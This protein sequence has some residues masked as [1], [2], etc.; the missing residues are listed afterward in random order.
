LNSPISIPD[1]PDP[2]STKPGTKPGTNGPA[3][4]DRRSATAK[5]TVSGAYLVLQSSGRW[6]DVFRLSSPAEAIIGRASSNQIVI[7]SDQASRRHARIAFAAG[8][9]TVEDMG[10]RNGTFVNGQKIAGKQDLCDRDVIA[11]AGYAIT[12]S[13]R[14]DGGAGEPVR[15]AES[16]QATDD[17][18][19]MEIDPESITDRRRHSAHLHTAGET[20]SATETSRRL[21]HL[22]F[23]VAQADQA[24]QAVEK[25]L[26]WI[27]DQIQF[28]TVGVYV[29]ES[30]Q[31]NASIADIPLVA[32]RQTGARS[33]RRPPIELMKSV[34]GPAGQSILARN[35]MGDGELA[36]ENSRGEMDVESVIMAAVRDHDERLLGLVHVTTTDDNPPLDSADLELIVAAG[37]ILAQSLAHLLDRQRLSRSLSKSRKQVRRLQEQIGDKVRIVGR[38]ESIGNVIQQIGLVAPTNSTVLIAGESGVGKELVASA[39][40]HTS[41]RKDG[42]FVCLNC[43]ALSPT[44]L[45]SELFGHEQGAF[46]GA[47]DRKLGKFEL[48]DGGTLML[49]EIGEM[50]A[51]VQAKFLRVLEGH[52]FERVG[53]Q[54]AIRADVRV[55]AATN[56]DLRSMVA[57]GEFRQDLYYRLHVVEIVVPPLRNRG[58]DCLQLADFF[59]QRFNA[60]MGRKIEGFTDAAKKRLVGYSW[61]GNIRELKNVIERAVVLNT[62]TQVDASDLTL[63]P[64][65]AGGTPPTDTSM[66]QIPLSELERTH[67]E[68]VLRHTEGNKSRAASILGIERSTLDRKLKKYGA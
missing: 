52:P 30:P 41:A 28:D 62:K 54:D 45:E 23:A 36:T 19:T 25:V 63:S 56:R 33:Y 9:W 13:R 67:I 43:A 55:V 59:L 17:Q 20:K 58:K 18:I 31:Q 10:S 22:A 47:T 34:G 32:T 2:T 42:P 53:G 57:S 64:A 11:V 15:S 3:G 4:P 50:S 35:V 5:G 49:D 12:F 48:A 68:Q 39:I 24:I 6:S 46:T 1:S 44:L 21:L 60:E 14:I 26:D 16:S 38:S 51:E 61:P 7:R 65:V 66:N 29:W 40:H 8:Q 27:A 37:E